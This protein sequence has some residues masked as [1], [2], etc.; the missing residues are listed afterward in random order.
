MLTEVKRVE[1]S[2]R[3]SYVRSR[4]THIKPTLRCDPL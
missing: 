3:M 1:L 4:S 2:N